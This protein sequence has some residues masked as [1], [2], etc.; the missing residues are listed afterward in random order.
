MPISSHMF[1]EQSEDPMSGMQGMSSGIVPM[2]HSLHSPPSHQPSHYMQF[3]LDPD[4]PQD[5]PLPIQHHPLPP[6]L[7]PQQITGPPL[8]MPGTDEQQQEAL[9]D[10]EEL[11]WMQQL[12]PEQRHPPTTTR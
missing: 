12:H 3:P 6:E 9:A 10:A 7:A 8:L 11:L 2:Q 5:L 1:M 4:Q